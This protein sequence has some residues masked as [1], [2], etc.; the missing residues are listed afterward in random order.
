MVIYDHNMMHHTTMINRILQQ[1]L[2]EAL[3]IFPVVL[4]TG[5]RQVGKSTMAM[6][7]DRAY[8]TL[9]NISRYDSAKHDPRRFVQELVQRCQLSTDFPASISCRAFANSPDL[10]GMAPDGADGGWGPQIGCC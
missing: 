9:D 4:L 1:P 7:L 10:N 2:I 3:D 8:V 6:N 5:A